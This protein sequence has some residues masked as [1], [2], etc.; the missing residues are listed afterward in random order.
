MRRPPFVVELKNIPFT[1]QLQILWYII[2]NLPRFSGGAFDAR[3]NGQ[4]M[5]EETMQ[6][7]G[8]GL[9]HCVM[10]SAKWYLE[11]FPPIRLPL[12]MPHRFFLVT[13]T[14]S[15]TTGRLRL[16]GHSSNSRQADKGADGNQ[17][18]GDS[19]ISA[20]MAFWVSLQEV[21][22]YGYDTPFNNS[23]STTTGRQDDDIDSEYASGRFG[24]KKGA[25]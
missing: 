22:E 9:I 10:T 17:R 12:K 5:A 13:P 8:A 15:M 19:L 21:T 20:V 2:D 14:F 4:Q 25:F 18:H 7:Y 3:G 16:W 24:N 1:S 6:K 11:A 23:S